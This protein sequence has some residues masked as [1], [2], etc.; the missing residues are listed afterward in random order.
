MVCERSRVWS[1][2][3]TGFVAMGLS[4]GFAA[5]P[6]HA[7]LYRWVDAKGVVNYSNIPPDGVQAKRIPDSQP[8]VSVVPPPD[9]QAELRQ[10]LREAE[11]LRRIEALEAELAA[12]RQA[13]APATVY[14]VPAAEPVVTFSAPVVYPYPIYGWPVTR[15]IVGRHPFKPF[16]PGWGGSPGHPGGRAPIAVPHG[17][18]SGLT[19]RARF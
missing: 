12:V 5:G 15:P 4:L 14:A 13:S 18:S 17:R 10:A 8:T 1:R 2:V 19:V 7:D 9:N 3:C 6:A 11:L 16:K